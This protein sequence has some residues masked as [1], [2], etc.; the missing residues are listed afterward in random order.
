MLRFLFDPLAGESYGTFLAFI[1]A[2]I[3][4]VPK[5]R[6]ALPSPP[7]AAYDDEQWAGASD[8]RSCPNRNSHRLELAAGASHACSIHDSMLCALPVSPQQNIRQDVSRKRLV[9]HHLIVLSV[10]SICRYQSGL[11]IAK[12]V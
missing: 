6:P 10:L 12:R 8:S 7:V 1:E 3:A 5:S 9:E 4:K 2:C 11:V